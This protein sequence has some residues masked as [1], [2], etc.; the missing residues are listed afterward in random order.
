MWLC[1]D[2]LFS[3][4][5]ACCGV[6]LLMT[7]LSSDSMLTLSELV[8]FAAEVSILA[9]MSLIVGSVVNVI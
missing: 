8:L 3:W 1:C 5:T 4:Q 2:F 7:V 9:A 6:L